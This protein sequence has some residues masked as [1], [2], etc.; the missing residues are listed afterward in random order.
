MMKFE[1]IQ[2]VYFSPTHTS[3]KI[4]DAIARGINIP[5]SHEIDLTYPIP[6]KTIRIENQLTIIA[7]PTYA[8]RIA[9]TAMER[10]QK[11][12]AQDTPVI[13]IALYGNR[14]YEDALLELKDQ[15]KSQGFIPIA[16]GAFIGEHSYSTSTMPTAANRPDELDLEIAS[17]FGKE[18]RRQ[19]EKYDSLENFPPLDVKGNFPYKEN[20][21]KTPAT[22]TTIE[23]LCTQCQHC[24][25]I[26]PVE[27]IELKEDIVSNPETCIKC[28]ACVKECPNEARVFNTPFSEFLFKNFHDRKEPELFRVKD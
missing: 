25:E 9:P 24:V 3:Q 14:D 15:V 19:L 2:L 8:G 26:C 1:S 20:K 21:P 28:C 5:V 11:L 12:Q 13:V 27:A 7:A 18:I 22:P 23:S 10:I 6:D 17:N 16:G 4:A